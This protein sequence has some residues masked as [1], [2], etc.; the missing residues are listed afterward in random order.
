MNTGVEQPGSRARELK[1]LRAL[2]IELPKTEIHLHIEA[3]ATVDTIWELMKKHD[4]TH[5]DVSSKADLQRKFNVTSL[6]EFIDLFINVIQNNFRSEDDLEYL[7]RDTR[8][9]LKRNN[10]V[11]AEIFFAP[12]K[13]LE[14]GLDFAKLVEILDAGARKILDAE[15]REIKFIIDVSRSFGVK[16][17]LHNLDLTI[18]NPLENVIGIGLGGAE[19]SGPA[20]D[21]KKVFAKAAKN[22]FHVVAHAGE[23]VGPDSIWDAIK[24]LKAERI[25]HGIS[26]VQDEK[27][28][29]YLVDKQIPLEICPTSNLFTQK[30]V[31]VLEEHPIRQ[32]YDRGI[33]VTLNTDDP[34]VF[35]IDL[36]DEYMSLTNKGF[37]SASEIVQLVK[38]NL[39]AT[40]LSAERKNEIWQESEVV[41]QRF[42]DKVSL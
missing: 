3:L 16:N 29:D 35:G 4:I 11:Y 8:E 10:I 19:S 24:V 14:N 1:N 34:T 32:F 15:G 25:G 40:F 9:Y 36:I 37:F 33:N 28:M 2:L 7:L 13:F 6:D 39:Y 30:Y 20:K 23:D 38:N 22:G 31:T 12:S 27:L 42:A 41:L 26:A 17:A 18:E 5:V 21:Y